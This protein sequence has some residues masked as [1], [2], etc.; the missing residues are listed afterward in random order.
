MSFC[1]DF[2]IATTFDLKGKYVQEGNYVLHNL[3]DNNHY[4]P[5]KNTEQNDWYSDDTWTNTRGLADASGSEESP[6]KQLQDL[7][8]VVMLMRQTGLAATVVQPGGTLSRQLI[9]YATTL[10]SQGALEAA[11]TYLTE[12]SGQ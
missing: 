5:C 7:V 9:R 8:E 12:G 6:T 10:A 1:F 2:K 3:P 11:L 4:K